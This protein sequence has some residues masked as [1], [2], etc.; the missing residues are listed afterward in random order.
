MKRLLAGS[1]FKE[2]PARRI[3]ARMSGRDGVNGQAM[4]GAIATGG[5]LRE[6]WRRCMSRVSSGRR[7]A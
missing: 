3:A 7:E 6:T 4:T 2:K 5:H 1:A